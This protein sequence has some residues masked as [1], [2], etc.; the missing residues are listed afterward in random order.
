MASNSQYEQHEVTV[1][2]S[3]KNTFTIMFN[4]DMPAS[5]AIEKC[6]NCHPA[7]NE[8]KVES[9][10]KDKKVQQFNE[11]CDFSSLFED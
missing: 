3:C 11:R 4:K 8:T 10:N 9:S 2:C 5:I 6:S 1:S 7:Y